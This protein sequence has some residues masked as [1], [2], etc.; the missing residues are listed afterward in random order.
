[1]CARGGLFSPKGDPGAS[2]QLHK[3]REKRGEE[4]LFQA[5]SLVVESPR[6]LGASFFTP[7]TAAES[8]V[9]H[10]HPA[11]PSSAHL[12]FFKLP[13]IIRRNSKP[14]PKSLEAWRIMGAGGG[15]KYLNVHK[16]ERQ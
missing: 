12:F 6:V 9:L 3:Q 16:S 11:P 4:L 14:P 13:V 8:S 5:Q 15:V 10:F 1:M 2:R 7:N